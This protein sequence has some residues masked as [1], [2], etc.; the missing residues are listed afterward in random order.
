MRPATE[1]RLSHVQSNEPHTQAQ[2][3]YACTLDRDPEGTPHGPLTRTCS[4]FQQD[5]R[6]PNRLSH[7]RITK[8]A[9]STPAFGTPCRSSQTVKASARKADDTNRHGLSTRARNTFLLPPVQSPGGAVE[10]RARLNN[11]REAITPPPPTMAALPIL[12]VQPGTSSNRRLALVG[13]DDVLTPR[14]L[15]R[16]ALALLRSCPALVFLR[17]RTKP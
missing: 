1:H 17:R 16:R 9:G 12:E 4:I 7:T 14:G 3:S 10:P 13:G 8:I 2:A 11:P 15:S 6:A 5:F